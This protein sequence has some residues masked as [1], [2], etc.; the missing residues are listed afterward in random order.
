MQC[1]WHVN[2]QS[3]LALL[4]S[5]YRSLITPVINKWPKCAVHFVAGNLAAA[6][7]ALINEVLGYAAFR[8]KLGAD[9]RR[10]MRGTESCIQCIERSRIARTRLSAAMRTCWLLHCA[11]Q[12]SHG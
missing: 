2:S 12:R 10:A 1:C 3:P 7:E 4:T 11:S 6:R 9:T 5:V 8:G